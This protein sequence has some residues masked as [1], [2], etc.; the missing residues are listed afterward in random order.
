MYSSLSLTNFQEE[1]GAAWI[2]WLLDA[3]HKIKYQKQ[4]PNVER[5]AACIRQHHPQYSNETVFQVRL[6]S[7]HD[8]QRDLTNIV[9]QHL[10]ESVRSG[11]IQRSEN[12]GKVTY[13]DPES[14]PRG[15]SKHGLK[16]GPSVDITKIFVKAVRELGES[17]G[18]NLRTVEKYINSCYDVELEQVIYTAYSIQ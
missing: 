6:W 17:G 12:K 3:I 9:L 10:E 4:R 16:L 1:N 13:K 15:K 18:S 14:G 8:C 2:S 5:V 11:Q 7:V